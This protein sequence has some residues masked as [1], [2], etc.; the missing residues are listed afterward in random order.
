MMKPRSFGD[1]VLS[2]VAY[3]A[4]SGLISFVSEPVQRKRTPDRRWRLPLKA[5]RRRRRVAEDACR[6]CKGT[7]QCEAC[8]PGTCRVCRG[9]GMQP[10]DSS[11]VVRLND[12][13]DGA[14]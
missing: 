5:K 8:M 7:G 6:H 11:L 3:V 12:L 2:V 13:W 9:S 4:L 1:V 10:R 14:S